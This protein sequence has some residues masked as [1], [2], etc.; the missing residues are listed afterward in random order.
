LTHNYTHL[1]HF[2][3][4]YY[5]DYLEDNKLTMKPQSGFRRLFS[6]VTSLLNGWCLKDI[7]HGLVMGVT[8]TDL[9]KAFRTMGLILF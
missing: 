5:T 2:V 4:I 8:F 6:T 7:D 3:S 9:Q 1:E